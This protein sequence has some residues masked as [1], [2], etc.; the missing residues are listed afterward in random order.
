MCSGRYEGRKVAK[1]AAQRNQ[2]RFLD[3]LWRG[4]HE[5]NSAV[6]ITDNVSVMEYFMNF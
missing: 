4:V 6:S 5:W 2:G 3:S 1:L